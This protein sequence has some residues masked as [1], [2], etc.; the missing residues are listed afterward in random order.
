MANRY[1]V[2]IVEDEMLIGNNIEKKVNGLGDVFYVQKLCKNGLDALREMEKEPVDVMI[3]DIRMPAMDGL[4]LIKTLRQKHCTTKIVILS[5]YSDFEYV[6]S[7]L[8]NHA[9]DYLL[10]PVVTEELRETMSRLQAKLD[11]E[12]GR[13]PNASH[14]LSPEQIA[15]QVIDYI[16]RNYREDLSVLDIASKMGYSAEYLGRVFKRQRGQS[17]LRHLT[18]F[19]INEAKKLL[20]SNPDLDINIVGQMVG[21]SDSSYFSRVFWKCTGMYPSEFRKNAGPGI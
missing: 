11:A 16:S 15:E 5:G 4:T 8:R 19:R 17:I 13:F 2:M 10:K 1:S 14:N 3:T 6:K 21:Y 12:R 7:A 20:L 9:E 18:G